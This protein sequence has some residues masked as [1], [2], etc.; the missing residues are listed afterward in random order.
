MDAEAAANSAAIQLVSFKEAM[1]DE[2]VVR[3]L[4]TCTHRCIADKVHMK[5]SLTI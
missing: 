3:C 4:Q 1:E 5:L 2:F